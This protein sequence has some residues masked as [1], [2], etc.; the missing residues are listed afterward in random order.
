MNTQLKISRI[1]LDREAIDSFIEHYPCSGLHGKY[2][3]RVDLD[4]N[5]NDLLDV[6]KV[7]N[8]MPIDQDQEWLQGVDHV[9]LSALIDDKMFDRYMQ[10]WIRSK[11]EVSCD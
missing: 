1:T 5:N 4:A 6:V 11:K 10:N 2:D 3:L 9:A 8:D 7:V